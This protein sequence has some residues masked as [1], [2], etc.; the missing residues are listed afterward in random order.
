MRSPALRLAPLRVP[1]LVALVATALAA[2]KP[3]PPP[4]PASADTMGAKMPPPNA[5]VFVDTTLVR[6]DSAMRLSLTYPRAQNGPGADAVNRAF[7]TTV[8]RVAD[9]FVALARESSLQLAGMPDV[10]TRQSTLEGRTGEPTV[11]ANVYSALTSYS[12]MVAGAAHPN[13]GMFVVNVD[14]R[15]RTPVALADLFA[16][17]TPYLDTLAARARTDLRAQM[18]ERAGGTPLPEDMLDEGTRATPASFAL[19]TIATDGLR[20]HF[21]PYAVA[22]YVFGDFT[23]V[24]PW[25]A[26]RPMLREN[27][28]ASGL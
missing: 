19:F 27:G 8:A 1:L 22:P 10:P 3:D 4:P 12:E 28:P 20:L 6:E 25:E 11:T 2:C 14:R 24:V 13:T 21:P 15:T 17:G 26:L 7:D 16:P 18:T 23:S 9:T 5:L